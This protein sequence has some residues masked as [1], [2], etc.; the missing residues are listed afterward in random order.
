MIS[1]AREALAFAPPSLLVLEPDAGARH[2]YMS[3]LGGQFAITAVESSDGAFAHLLRTPA[4]VVMMDVVLPDGDGIEV[5]RAAKSLENAPAV[6]ITTA[7]VERVPDAIEAGCDSVLLKPFAPNLL[8]ARLSRL[9]RDRSQMLRM[10]SA[11]NVA[12]AGHR[13]ERSARLMNGTNGFWPNTPCPSC[14]HVGVTSFDYA[15]YRRAWY[16]CLACRKVW[17]AARAE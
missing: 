13:R 4:A 7:D 16:A 2:E 17:I 3:L 12:R 6:L 1:V 5:C 14:G 11:D 9:A 8:S 10:R 15:A